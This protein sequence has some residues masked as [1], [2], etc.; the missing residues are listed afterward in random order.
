MKRLI[1]A[2]SL[3]CALFAAACADSLLGPSATTSNALIFDQV[4]SE[5][6]QH[7]SFFDYKHI[8]WDSLRAV[9][10]PRAIAAANDGQLADVIGGMLG[11]LRDVHVSLDAGQRTYRYLC[12]WDTAQIYDN[13]QTVE[14]R[15]LDHATAKPHLVYGYVRPGVG[16][17]RIKDFLGGGW[18]DEVDAALAAMDAATTMIVDVRD[19]FG[20]ED[21]TAIAIAGRFADRTHDY[22]FIR[23]RNGPDH[24]DFT[25]FISEHVSPLGRRFA[26]TVYVL[27]NRRVFSSAEDFVLAMRTLPNVTVVGDTT[28]GASGGPLVRELPNGWT[29]QI[30]EWMEFTPDKRTFESIGLAPDV[31]AKSSAA[32]WYAGSD[33]ALDRALSLVHP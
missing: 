33:V 25:G 22:G 28:A 20:G 21:G 6:D 1:P 26:G 9:Y 11:E 8:D 15:Y 14:T 10:R 13:A 4:W 19:N 7:Y 3:L 32:A 16:Y 31:V 2:V 30:S 5:T 23:L 24:G 18:T 27:T 17:L 29:F 12:R